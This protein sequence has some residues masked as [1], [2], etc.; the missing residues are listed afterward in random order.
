MEIYKGNTDLLCGQF[1]HAI[2]LI[3][4]EHQIAFVDFSPA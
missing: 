3:M 1:T 4:P 2:M